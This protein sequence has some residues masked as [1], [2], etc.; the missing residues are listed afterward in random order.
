MTDPP[1]LVPEDEEAV[2]AQSTQEQFKKMSPLQIRAFWKTWEGV[3]AKDI[4]ATLGVHPGTISS[5]KRLP[6]WQEAHEIEAQTRD[7]EF[8]ASLVALDDKAIDMA[9]KIY[10]GKNTESKIANAQ[11]GLL[12]TRLEIGKRPLINR[13]GGD[14]TLNIGSVNIQN[15]TAIITE[16]WTPEEV[17]EYQRTKTLP[18]R[19]KNA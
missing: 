18:Q 1:V 15:N 16:G 17:L 19:V 10:D 2:E 7:L 5:W 8:H 13:R 3:P 11:V 6:E 12:R 9:E 14:Q 4:A